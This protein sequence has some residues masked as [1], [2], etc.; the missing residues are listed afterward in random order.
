MRV[1]SGSSNPSNRSL[2]PIPRT[3]SR[4]KFIQVPQVRRLQGMRTYKE[5]CRAADY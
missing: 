1:G 2:V 5:E 3:E 4:E